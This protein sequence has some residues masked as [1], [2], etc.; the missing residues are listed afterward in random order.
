MGSD[1]HLRRFL[2]RLLSQRARPHA[3]RKLKCRGWARKDVRERT[4]QSSAGQQRL[5]ARW[6]GAAR[7]R[8]CCAPPAGSSPAPPSRSPGA[9]TVTSTQP[10][11]PASRPCQASPGGGQLSCGVRGVPSTVTPAPA[12][13]VESQPS[14][15]GPA[16][17]L[18]GA[19]RGGG[20]LVPDAHGRRHLARRR[21][22]LRG[23][24]Q[25]LLGGRHRQRVSTISQHLL[26]GRQPAAVSG[27][28]ATCA[29]SAA[30]FRDNHVGSEVGVDA[31]VP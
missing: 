3:A 21:P 22:A 16:P 17:T 23:S 2:P 18:V 27:T 8:F 24:A 29:V 19:R 15:R 26:G 31:R 25:R 28:T 9:Y 20:L 11:E 6:A 14:G 30:N 13:S 10:G 7:P 4:T 5:S 1:W 12:L